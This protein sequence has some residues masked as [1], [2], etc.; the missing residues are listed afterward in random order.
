ML[1]KLFHAFFAFLTSNISDYRLNFKNLVGNLR[2]IEMRN[3]IAKLEFC[4]F[5]TDGAFQ[6]TDECTD[7]H[8][9]II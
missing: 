8:Q 5:N 4:S 9:K 7:G 2:D 6:A 3:L 1:K